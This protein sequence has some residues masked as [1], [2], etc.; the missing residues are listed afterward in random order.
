RFNVASG[1]DVTPTVQTTGA[2]TYGDAVR[3]VQ[4][5]VLNSTSSGNITFNSTV[6][7]DTA[8]AIALTVNTAGNEQFNGRVGGTHA[9]LSLTTDSVTVGGQTRFNV[10]SG[11]DV[12]P[13]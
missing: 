11:A 9:L 8:T 2:Q 6:D 13:T 7:S 10:A 3:L 1:A 4:T 12:T 5:T